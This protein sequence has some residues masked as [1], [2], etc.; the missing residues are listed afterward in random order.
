MALNRRQL[1]GTL[2]AGLA[3]T[4]TGCSRPSAEAP[5][6]SGP[7]RGANGEV[8]WAAVR[9]LFPLTRD[10]I[11]LAMFL[12]VSHPKPVAEAIDRFRRKIDAD[13]LWIEAAAFE[14]SEGRPF[15][16]I[17]TALVEYV[18]GTP[19]ELCLTSNTTGGLAMAYHGLR[20]RADQEVLTTEHDHY[21]QHE[22][23]RFA[24]E[25]S[26][27]GVRYIAL[28]DRPADASADQMVDRVR[29]AIAPK[30]RAVGVTWVHSST[31]V[32]VPIARIAE[33]VATA[34]RGRASADR[35]LL[36]V[37]GVHGFANQDVDVAT[38]GCDFFAAGTHKWLF[39]PRG[40][41]FLW[42]RKDVWPEMRPTI[43]TFDPEVLQTWEAWMERKPLPPTQAAF[44]SPGGFVAFEHWLAIPAAVELHRSIG[45]AQIAARIASL[46]GAFREGA[47]KIR[48]LTLHTPKDPAVSGGLSCF[49]IAGV[50]AED[51]P[52]RLAE[53]RIRTNSSP[54]KTSYARVSAGVM[55]FP[56]EIDTVLRELR[57]LS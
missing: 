51:V 31:G 7:I 37:D 2:A 41:G 1:L 11:H 53:K 9:D 52:H 50:K 46:N 15:H 55:N 8:D 32:K 24:A 45:R 33:V 39:A 34:N 56:E 23:I 16:A 4:G 5:A 44:L 10:W 47:T 21:S 19:E 40:T 6:K 25:R 57:A 36:I 30:T 13:P 3:W 43:P 48:G 42:G 54:Y 12:L 18:G 20:I 35:C 49:E 17:K 38:L 27:A 26:G 29:K 22:S 28:Y 14:D